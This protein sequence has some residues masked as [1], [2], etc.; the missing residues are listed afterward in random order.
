MQQQRIL[1]VLTDLE[2]AEVSLPSLKYLFRYPQTARLWSAHLIA[3]F[4]LFYVFVDLKAPHT[5]IFLNKL[6]FLQIH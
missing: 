3:L 6:I 2:A 1:L 5:K 4:H